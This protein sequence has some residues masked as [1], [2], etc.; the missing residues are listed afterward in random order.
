MTTENKPC[1]KE[2]ASMHLFQPKH[3]ILA[4]PVHAPGT[5]AGTFMVAKLAANNKMKFA[6][7]MWIFFLAGRIINIFLLPS[8]NW[9]AVVDLLCDYV[10]MCY[11]GYKLA[12]NK[13]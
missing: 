11:I 4:F 13:K 10:T 6:I 1:L 8:P 3:F 9:F 7:G 2:N 5:F 12:E